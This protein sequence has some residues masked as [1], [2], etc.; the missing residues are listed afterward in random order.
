MAKK[1][2]TTKKRED[3]ISRN[4]VRNTFSFYLRANR[5]HVFVDS[6]RGIGCPRF[7][8]FYLQENGHTLAIAPYTKKDFH[9]HRV[10][11]AV[12][13]GTGTH[14]ME[15]SS[16]KLCQIIA[17]MY[18]WDSDHSYRVPGFVLQDRTAAIFNLGLAEVIDK[19]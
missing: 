7:I 18:H 14:G 15:V 8:R 13:T 10:P 19:P 9:S 17:R 12:Y 4:K 3:S 6:L 2:I 1:K 11:P 16:M 5:I